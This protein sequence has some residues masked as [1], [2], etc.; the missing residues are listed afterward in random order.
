[1]NYNNLLMKIN[2][3]QHQKQINNSLQNNTENI[4]NDYQSNNLPLLFSKINKNN[5][6]NE[7]S[8]N[9]FKKNNN[10]YQNQITEIK[11]INEVEKNQHN[12]NIKQYTTNDLLLFER[13][14]QS[15]LLD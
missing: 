7:F 1:M 6:Y 4:N 5:S 15:S 3:D 10:G 13:F 14:Y 9:I 2:A 12:Q 8:D 11:N